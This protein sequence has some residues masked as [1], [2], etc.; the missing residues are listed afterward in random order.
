MHAPRRRRVW[1]GSM[2]Y[3]E[4]DTT[5]LPPE[6]RFAWWREVV[7]QG[8][9]PVRVA[10]DHAADF[11][12]RAG[13]IPLGAVHLTTMSFPSLSSERPA[14]LVRRSDP[15][16]YELTLILGGA[17][18]IAQERSETRLHAG[19]FAMWTSSRPYNGQALSG[20]DVGASRAVMLHLPQGLVPLPQAKLRPLLARGLSARSGMGRIL[21][22]YLESL[23]QQAPALDEDMSRR[24]DEPRS[25]HRLPR[26]AGRRAGAPPAG[27]PA[28]GPAGRDRHLH[29]G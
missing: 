19:D 12:G 16:T 23:V 20:P 25:G 14:H 15:E 22:Q 9:A 26:S 29:R 13:F 5:S 28:R 17:M 24:P 6:D 1:R 18:H 21:A 2:A 3:T 27:D 11:V 7:G 8:V 10:T 4:L